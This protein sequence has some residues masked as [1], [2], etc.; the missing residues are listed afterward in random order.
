VYFFS[1]EAA[2]R[3]AVWAARQFWGLP[4]F[5]AQMSLSQTGD[6]ILYQSRRTSAEVV[7]K[8]RCRL[9]ELLGPL[10]PESLEFYFLER[11]LLFADRGEQLYV[12]QV[13]HAPYPAQAALV[14]E[15]EDQLL[16]AAGL[17]SI[18]GMPAFTHFAAGVDVEV[19][20]LKPVRCG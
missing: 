18:T 13:H 5:H 20:D 6:E 10:P 9:G 14:L 8:V 15:F 2:S 7:H 4:Y 12:G 11:Y 16:K 1:L 17:E 19:F 3:I